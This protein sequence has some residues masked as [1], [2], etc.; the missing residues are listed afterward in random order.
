MSYNLPYLVPTPMEA[1]TSGNL[2]AARPELATFLDTATLTDRPQLS[3]LS[4]P[5]HAS[6]PCPTYSLLSVLVQQVLQR[7]GDILK[8]LCVCLLMLFSRLWME[9]LC[10]L[11]QLF[12][13]AYHLHDFIGKRGKL[14]TN[15][16]VDTEHC[17]EGSVPDA[18]MV[19][20][21]LHELNK[22]QTPTP[23]CCP[24]VIHPRHKHVFDVSVCSLNR[25]L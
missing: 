1:L 22:F 3:A 18:C 24:V 2:S 13:C 16:D 14:K 19:A 5:T 15:F 20:R 6:L 25:P 17:F 4:S 10:H 12:L 21:V 8:P 9:P 23:F 7:M 11:L